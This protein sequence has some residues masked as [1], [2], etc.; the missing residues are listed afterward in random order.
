ME[1][2]LRGVSEGH[3]RANTEEGQRILDSI[4]TSLDRAHQEQ[5]Q[6]SAQ[7]QQ[8]ETYRKIASISEEQ[9]ASINANATQEFMNEIQKEQSLRSIEETMVNHPEQAKARAD[10]FV[11]SKVQHYFEEFKANEASSASKI[12]KIDQHNIETFHHQEK[13][14]EPE[15]VYQAH[16]EQLKT[17]ANA[18]GLEQ[19]QPIDKKPADQVEQML[20]NESQKITTEKERLER[21]PNQNQ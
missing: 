9:A 1:T 21:Q 5:Q 11:Q 13:L 16:R 4:S 19:T 6:A 18:E 7:F 17:Q 15:S 2:A 10:E 3:Y 14:K 20:L 8:A 12:E